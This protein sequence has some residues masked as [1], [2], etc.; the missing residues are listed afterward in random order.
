MQ[1]TKSLTSYLIFSA[2]SLSAFAAE[3]IQASR[4]PDENDKQLQKI[5]GA[6]IRKNPTS[7]TMPFTIE[8]DG[9][10]V[11]F[12]PLPWAELE[13][14]AGQLVTHTLKTKKIERCKFIVDVSRADWV[15]FRSWEESIRKKNCKY[16]IGVGGG[17]DGAR[18]DRVDG[19]YELYHSYLSLSNHTLAEEIVRSYCQYHWKGGTID[20]D[21]ISVR[22]FYNLMV[23][24][25]FRKE[26]FEA[27][28]TGLQG[29]ILVLPVQLKKMRVGACQREIRELILSTLEK[30]KERYVAFVFNPPKGAGFTINDLLNDKNDPI[31]DCLHEYYVLATIHEPEEQRLYSCLRNDR[32]PTLDLHAPNKTSPI[33]GIDRMGGYELLK[34]FLLEKFINFE[35][36]CNI[37]TGWGAGRTDGEPG[38]FV[39]QLPNWLKEPEIKPMIKRC[40]LMNGGGMYKIIFNEPIICDLSYPEMTNNVFG[41]FL[42]SLIEAKGKEDRRVI[43]K[44]NDYGVAVNFLHR[45]L[46]YFPEIAMAMSPYGLLKLPNEVR[47]IL[48]V[49]NHLEPIL[50]GQLMDYESSANRNLPRHGRLGVS[51]GRMSY[52]S[53]EPETEEKLEADQKVLAKGKKP[54]KSKAKK[55]KRARKVKANNNGKGSVSGN[56]KKE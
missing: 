50:F 14:S 9:A 23:R 26:H 4:N 56:T 37:C 1:M 45:V 27:G 38:Y 53:D 42:M 15:R 28:K 51:W 20:D 52:I 41:L 16:P 43:L 47:L 10:V 40:I 6:A 35:R 29:R 36:S 5:S 33:G 46:L 3:P 44:T 31:R 12:H 48:N 49:Q 39:K 30:A 54:G 34:S 11:R 24:A 8:E 21:L 2:I 7:K 17:N 19:V 25:G 13:A 18:G 55:R 22:T 32:R